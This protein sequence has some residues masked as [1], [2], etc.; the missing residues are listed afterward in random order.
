[1]VRQYGKFLAILFRDDDATFLMCTYLVHSPRARDRK[2]SS[3]GFFLPA[4]H[5][6]ILGASQTPNVK[7]KQSSQRRME[8]DR[9]NLALEMFPLAP[10]YQD[11]DAFDDAPDQDAAL[12]V[13]E[14]L[15][16]ERALGGR[17]SGHRG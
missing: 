5:V 16:E 8:H 15:P 1:M 12:A 17:E 4:E 13:V 3:A 2:P 7:H 9:Q 6:R 14:F 11:G 10:T